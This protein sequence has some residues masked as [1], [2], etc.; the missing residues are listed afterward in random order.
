MSQEGFENL[1]YGLS[2]VF[3]LIVINGIMRFLYLAYTKVQE[4]KIGTYDV[5]DVGEKENYDEH[6]P[7]RV[8]Q[9]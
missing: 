9:S 5:G 7:I 4:W 3:V 8:P 2:V 6:G 1:G